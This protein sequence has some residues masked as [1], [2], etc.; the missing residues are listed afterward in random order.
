MK[1]SKRTK[2][3]RV[4]IRLP[5]YQYHTLSE[6]A[7]KHGTSLSV[8]LRALLK[9]ALDEIIDDNGDERQQG[10]ISDSH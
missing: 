4:D 9:K 2:E 1:N 3:R 7:K 6:L 5:P 10:D 8:A